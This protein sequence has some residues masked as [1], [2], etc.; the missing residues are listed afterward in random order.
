MAQQPAKVLSNSD[1]RLQ[2]RFVAPQPSVEEVAINAESFCKLAM[3]GFQTSSEVG[4]PA[5]PIYNAMIEVPMG[6]TLR[7]NV[8]N[9][10]TTTLSAT[11]LGLKYPIVPAQPSRSKSD[12]SRAR[13]VMDRALYGQDD[14][15]GNDLVSV[16]MVGVARDTRIAMVSFSPVAYNPATGQTTLCKEVTVDICFDGADLTATRNLK[17]QHHSTAFTTGTQMLA[18]LPTTKAVRTSAPIRMLI[19]AHSSFRGQMDGFVNWK[20]RKGFITDVV[21]T[22]SIGTTTTQ[23]QNY[24][25]SQYSDATVERPAPTYLLLVGDHQ[26]IPAFNGRDNSGYGH[27]T[28]LYYASWTTGDN[29]PDC[30][31]GRFSAQNVAQLNAQIEKTLVYEQYMFPDPSFLDRAV[32]VAGVDQGYSS[33]HGYTHGDPTLDFVATNYVNGDNGYSQ[34]LYYKN[35]ASHNPNAANVTVASNSNATA[36]RNAYNQGAGWI[37]YTAHGDWNEWSIPSFTTTHVANMT[38]NGKYGFMIGNCCL[39]GKFDE[40]TCFGE[41]L[42]RKENAGAVDYFGCSDVSYWN[43]DV[44]WS[45]GLRSSINANMSTAYNANN[46]G[47]YDRLFHT[48]GE[49]FDQQ[50]FTAGAMVMAG[51]MAVQTSTSSS[52]KRYYWEIYHLFGDP[53]VMPWLTQAETMQCGIPT[54]VISGATSLAVSVA[55]YS[56]VALTTENDHQL[57]G[58]TYADNMGNALITFEAPLTPGIYEVTASA[59]NYLTAFVPVTCIAPNGPYAVATDVQVEGSRNVG[60]TVRLSMKLTNLGNATAN[61][62]KVAVVASDASLRVL[63]SV[64]TV[65]SLAAGDTIEIANVFPMEVRQGVAD[66]SAIAYTVFVTWNG[67]NDTVI[68]RKSMIV[69]APKVLLA[70][71]LDR[72]NVLAGDSVRVQIEMKNEGHAA[73]DNAVLTI[74]SAYPLVSVAN[75]T[76]HASL[77]AGETATHT[78]YIAADE[79]MLEGVIVPL[80]LRAGNYFYNTADSIEMFVGE[81]MSEDFETGDFARFAWQH[82]NNSSWQVVSA[83]AYE[84]TYCAKS[85]AIG[86]SAST[87]LSLSWNASRADSIIFYYKV[88]SEANYDKFTF[89]IDNVSKLVASGD[90][91]WTRAAFPVSQGNH[92]FKFEYKKDYS[93]AS[94]SDCVWIDNVLLPNSNDNT[95]ALI[96]DTVCRNAEYDFH[97]TTIATDI[98][99]R[100]IY[101]DTVSQVVTQLCLTVVDLP[102]VAISSEKT[103]VYEGESLWLYGN[104]AERYMWSTGEVSDSIYVTPVTTTTYS[105]EGYMGSCSASDEITINVTV[106]ID[107]VADAQVI[108]YPNPAHSVVTV[109]AEDL[110]RV[111]LYNALGQRMKTYLPNGASQ[112]IALEGMSA[113]AYYIRIATE[114]AT[115]L[116]QIIVK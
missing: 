3:D 23:I 87:S 95:Y 73:I 55:P 19:V 11:A 68:A 75:N 63:D 57:L 10:N 5:L 71:S 51:N 56:Y 99:G 12:T 59:Q 37:N 116:K 85:G 45:M 113:G 52:F 30:Y 94:N 69:N 78:C 14:F 109:Q 32:L 105:V 103:T 102:Q 91:G 108:V 41:S 34:V 26:Q 72:T 25:L 80:Y 54:T 64:Y 106:A 76:F 2:L 114:T 20:R 62:C 58:A 100:S 43:E 38:N 110:R 97:G 88:S 15:Y 8:V 49:A 29:I 4:K 98:V 112:K 93:Q 115:V 24:I 107:E 33:D 74:G 82:S 18:T 39:S 104:G 61:N 60:D 48:H 9:H 6:A 31:Y 50:Y 44:Y 17:Q 22:D 7:V 101:T 13:L 92:T 67:G 46:L 66:Q 40:Q 89:Y 83:G 84:G 16:E 42:L 27:I 90:E 21:Y 86:H 65:A 81:P 35:N 96:S 53:S 47:M 70:Y 28:D 79:A 111:E 1:T 77:T 36:V